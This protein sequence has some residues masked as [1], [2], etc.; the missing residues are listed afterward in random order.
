VALGRAMTAVQG[1]EAVFWNPAGLAR[2]TDRRILVYRGNNFAGDQTAISL[3][4]A[5]EGLGTLGL[6]YQLV[7]VGEQESRDPTGTVVGSISVRSHLAV[8]SFAT[9]LSDWLSTGLNFKFVRFSESCRG[10]CPEAGVTATTVAV[11][12]GFQVSP[13]RNRPMRFGAMVAHIGPRLQFINAEQAD[14]LPTRIRVAAAYQALNRL[15]PTGTFALWLNLE[16]EDRWRDPGEPTVYVGT[17]FSAGTD[18]MIFARAGYVFRDLDQ[19]RGA[20]IGLGLHYDR[21]E[22][23]IA[24]SLASA[25]I[26]PD[27]EPIYV[28]LGIVF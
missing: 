13:F 16:V 5:R 26:A 12:A 14:P 24:R 15:S 8:A 22:V 28:T 17:E 6:S 11:D 19:R 25:S 27:T 9:A 3:V 20:A 23:G 4:G 10:Q 7:D 2:L 18:E 21:V 1:Q